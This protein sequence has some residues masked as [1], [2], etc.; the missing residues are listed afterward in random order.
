MIY[1]GNGILAEL[2]PRTELRSYDLFGLE[3]PVNLEIECESRVVGTLSSTEDKTIDIL[4]ET[5]QLK[6][7][8]Y[9]S[10]QKDEQV[11][12]IQILSLDHQGL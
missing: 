2:T 12:T 7:K 10:P 1:L 3:E 9:N 4:L 8:L 5:T 6:K 11:K